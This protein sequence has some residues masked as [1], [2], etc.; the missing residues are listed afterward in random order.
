MPLI[1]RYFRLVLFRPKRLQIAKGP[2]PHQLLGVS[3]VVGGA[4]FDMI[5]HPLAIVGP[6]HAI[7]ELA[8]YVAHQFADGIGQEREP[9]IDPALRPLF[10]DRFS[11]CGSNPEV[12][13]LF[14]TLAEDRPLAACLG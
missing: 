11:D 5:D 13:L 14:G 4:G 3:H 12:G 1:A 7:P 10:V 8:G 2:A 9:R 6:G